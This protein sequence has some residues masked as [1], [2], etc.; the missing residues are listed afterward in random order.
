[1]DKYKETFETWNKIAELYQN[2]FMDME[3]YNDTYNFICNSITKPKA[4]LLEIGCGPGNITKYLLAKK[5]DFKILGI[6]MAPNMVAL[7]QKNN[8]TANFKVMDIRQLYKMDEKFD[9]IIGGFCLPYLSTKE[10]NDLL[11]NAFHLLNESGLIYVSF[12]DGDPSKS[13]FKE[14]SAGRVFFN[15]H[16]IND[17]KQQLTS[18]NFGDLTTFEVQ[19]KTSETAFETHTIITARKKENRNNF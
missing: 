2:K 13:D 1:M 15:Y 17:I 7:A 18:A 3:L 9:G 19:Y 8:P 14:G 6:D 10:C 4:R 5:R 12:V 11:C 16:R